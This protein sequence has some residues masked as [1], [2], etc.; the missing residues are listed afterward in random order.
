MGNNNST[1]VVPKKNFGS[2]NPGEGEKARPGYHFG[3]N[4]IIYNGIAIELLPNEKN[5]M[6]LGNG[7]A[8][9]SVRVFY[10]GNAIPEAIPKTFQVINRNKVKDIT[11]NKELIDLD[12]VLGM[13]FDG[14]TKR[15]YYRGNLVHSE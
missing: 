2:I 13:D 4:K 8:K 3:K 7:Y 5:L 11:S 15:I 1:N 9:T 14:T 10:Q 6:K 12:S